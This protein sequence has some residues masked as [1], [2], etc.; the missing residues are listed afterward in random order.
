MPG[1]LPDSA[2]HFEAALRA[3]PDYVDA[4]AN[5]AAALLQVPG[6]TPEAIAHYEAALRIKPDSAEVHYNLGAILSNV[7]TRLPEAIEHFEA[8][9]RIL[10]D[11]DTHYALAV[12][13]SK[14]PAVDWRRSAIWKPRCGSTPASHPR[15]KCWHNCERAPES[16]AAR[17][18]PKSPCRFALT[19]HIRRYWHPSCP[20]G[21]REKRR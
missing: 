5:L 3:K 7:P 4:H 20:S 18:V 8:A 15:V 14:S 12:A 10:P 1:R 9:L 2:R 13:L 6:R 17:L 11:A 16:A 21:T 19:P